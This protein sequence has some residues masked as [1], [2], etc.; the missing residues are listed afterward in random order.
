MKCYTEAKPQTWAELLPYCTFAYNITVNTTT[1]FTPFEL[2][3]DRTVTL[4]TSLQKHRPIYNY[5]NY[6]QLMKKEFIDAWQMAKK[7]ID[8]KKQE[9][10]KYY[11]K[12]INDIDV[13][14]GDQILIKTQTKD[15]KYEMAW[16]GPYTVTAVPSSKYVHYRD[17]RNTER[18]IGKDHIKLAKATFAP[19]NML[20]DRMTNFIHAIRQEENFLQQIGE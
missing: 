4:P 10:K 6:A 19:I 7:M 20:H 13:K 8:Q 14:M 18:K 9:R 16:H 5:A 15:K 1:G 2:V 3:F 11:D 12:K 17:K